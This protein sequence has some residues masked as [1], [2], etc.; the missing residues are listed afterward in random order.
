MNYRTIGDECNEFGVACID[1]K[2]PEHHQNKIIN[3]MEELINVANSEFLK[4]LDENG[5]EKYMWLIVN[6]PIS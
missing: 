5:Y 1:H 2:I 3:K 6:K 4:W